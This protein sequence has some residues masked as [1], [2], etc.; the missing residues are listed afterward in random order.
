MNKRIVDIYEYMPV[1]QELTEQGKEV[2]L[3]ITGSS[4]APFLIHERDYVFFKKP[5]RALEKGDMVFYRR[6]TGQYVMH[7]IRRVNADGSF[8]IIGDG[9]SVIERGVRREQIF[10]LI[11]KVKRKGK[12]LSDGDFCWEF[13]KHIWLHMIPLRMLL[14]RSYTSLKKI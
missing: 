14:V 7:R 13:F 5:D 10:G 11:T 9:Q 3:L 6:R 8:D 1:L 2:S 4:M 12:I